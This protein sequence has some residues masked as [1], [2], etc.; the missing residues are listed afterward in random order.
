MCVCL[1]GHCLL[2]GPLVQ[3]AQCMRTAHAHCTTAVGDAVHCK[4][5]ASPPPPP[6]NRGQRR[7]FRQQWQK[8]RPWLKYINDLMHC[9]ACRM[10]PQPGGSPEWAQ[11]TSNF[12]ASAV[13]KHDRSGPHHVALAMWVSNGQK[14]SALGTLP[15]RRPDGLPSGVPRGEERGFPAGLSWGSVY[16]RALW[17]QCP[18]GLPLPVLCPWHSCGHSSALPQHPRHHHPECRIL[19]SCFGFGHGQGRPQSRASLLPDHV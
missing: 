19:G 11:G 2:A 13:K 6:P 3:C 1:V 17:W 14:F 7:L 16:D 9:A 12:R 18:S 4:A 8:G 5:C 10:Y 15:R